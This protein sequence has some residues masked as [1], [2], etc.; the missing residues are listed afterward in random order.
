MLSRRHDPNPG[1]RATH[2]RRPD[3][4]AGL[5]PSAIW[6]LANKVCDRYF[7]SPPNALPVQFQA[8]A[9]SSTARRVPKVGAV[10][11]QPPLRLPRR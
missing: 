2:D 11:P 10:P 8:N 4:V 7:C 9:V 6:D 1:L 3:A 5:E